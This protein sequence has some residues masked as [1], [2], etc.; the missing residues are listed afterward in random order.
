MKWTLDTLIRKTAIFG[1]LEEDLFADGDAK[2]GEYL[3]DSDAVKLKNK[4]IEYLNECMDKVCREK[5]V[6]FAT[7]NIKDMDTAGLS[8]TFLAVKSI[9]NEYGIILDYTEAAD[10]YINVPDKDTDDIATISYYYLVDELASLTDKLVIPAGRVD[11]KLYCH[12]AAYQVLVHETD[13]DSQNKAI[14]ELQMF[15]DVYSKISTVET[16]FNAEEVW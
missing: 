13:S 4:I 9:V 12:Y 8:N 6:M 2:S 3:T 7:E 15:N 16:S 11:P 10:G 5:Q 1:G 14:T